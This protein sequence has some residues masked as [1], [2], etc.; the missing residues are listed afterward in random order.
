[1]ANFKLVSANQ[2]QVWSTDYIKEYT[3]ESGFL[4]YM[5]TGANSIIRV[6][7]SLGSQKGALVHFPY[8]RALAGA[9]VTGATNLRGSED[10][11]TNLSCAVKVQLMRNG[12]VVPGSE[13]YQTELDVMNVARDSLKSWS[14][15]KLRTDLITAFQGIPVAGGN[16]TDGNPVEDSYTSYASATTAQKNAF[17][18]ANSDRL[19]FGVNANYN[20]THATALGNI[21]ASQKMGATMIN[22]AR[23]LARKTSNYRITPYRSDATAGR[24]YLVMYVGPEGFRDCQTDNVIYAANKDARDRDVDSNPIFQSG[25]LIYNAV[26]I[27][28]IPE[29]PLVGNV[30]A[31]GAT[32]GHAILCGQSA[33][34]VAYAQMAT[35]TTDNWDFGHMV[36][37][38]IKEIRGQNKFSVAG[39]QTG[40]VSIFHAAAP[41]A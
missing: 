11:L 7:K 20:A 3:R 35:P 2:K 38:G 37:A 26:I 34:A 19:L 12:V 14:A 13:T 33:A 39:V 15:S 10:T 9:G 4:P 22:A 32:V 24:E 6:D 28:E 1:M 18:V 31:S 27:R 16:D 40:C 30:G 29:M 25:D 5:G 17:N 8:F 36:G 21:T 23:N 41:D